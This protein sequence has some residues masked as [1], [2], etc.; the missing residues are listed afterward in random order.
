MAY[1]VLFILFLMSLGSMRAD[2]GGGGGP[3][4]HLKTSQKGMKRCMRAHESNTF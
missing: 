1:E 2:P 4:G 3:G